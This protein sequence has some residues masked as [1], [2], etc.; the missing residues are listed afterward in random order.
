MPKNGGN[1]WCGCRGNGCCHERLLDDSFSP[2]LTPRHS[3][4]TG[5]I[6]TEFF[7][8]DK[9][10]YIDFGNI[11]NINFEIHLLF[12]VA[13]LLEDKEFRKGLVD[14]YIFHKLI[15]LTKTGRF[16]NNSER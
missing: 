15:A 14:V 2:I 8:G 16:Q 12:L 9:C 13:G 10:K 3:L 7:C 5:C 4:E 1:R 11:T 6:F